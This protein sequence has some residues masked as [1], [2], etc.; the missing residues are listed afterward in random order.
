LNPKNSVRVI[1]C[2]TKEMAEAELEGKA[3]SRILYE[4]RE[5]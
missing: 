1:L 4:K 2:F 3:E 5:D